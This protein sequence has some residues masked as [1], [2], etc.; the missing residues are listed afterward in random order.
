[1]GAA[2]KIG[3]HRCTTYQNS[4]ATAAGYQMDLSPVAGGGCK[5]S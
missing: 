3:Q 2:F 4:K 1:M 5:G